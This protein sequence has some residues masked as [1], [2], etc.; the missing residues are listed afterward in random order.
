MIDCNENENVNSKKDD[1]NKTN[2][3]QDMN[4]ETNIDNIVCLGNA[5]SLCNK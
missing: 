2:I 3:D 1:I 5:M 4:I